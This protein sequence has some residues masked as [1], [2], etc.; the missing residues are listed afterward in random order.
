VN[1]GKKVNWKLWSNPIVC[2]ESFSENDVTYSVQLRE[3]PRGVA[4]KWRH[5]IFDNFWHPTT[6]VVT[7][8]FTFYHRQQSLTPLQRTWRHLGT[9]PI[10]KVRSLHLNDS[11]LNGSV[12]LS[13]CQFHQHFT[14]SFCA[15]ILLP[16]KLQSQ[17]VSRE[18]LRKVLLFKKDMCKMLIKLTLG[19]WENI[20]TLLSIAAKNGLILYCLLGSGYFWKNDAEIWNV[21]NGFLILKWRGNFKGKL[22]ERINQGCIFWPLSPPLP[23]VWIYAQFF[24]FFSPDMMIT[25]VSILN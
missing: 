7:F 9:A 12:L 21:C 16:K 25:S 19:G 13:R 18:K 22:E 5:A 11:T 1:N 14:S 3:G 10:H 4:H 8:V 20:L 24:V 2:L 23:R 15:D 6:L 17:N